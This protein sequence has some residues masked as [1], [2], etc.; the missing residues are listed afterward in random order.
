M[1]KK[2]VLPD[3]LSAMIALAGIMAKEK[4]NRAERRF[5]LCDRCNV[6]HLT[7]KVDR[8]AAVA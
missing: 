5:Y 7:S 2:R 1:C 4:G 3:R 6:W 8:Y